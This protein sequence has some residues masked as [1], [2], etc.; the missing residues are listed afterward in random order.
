MGPEE[1][2]TIVSS[3]I[4]RLQS[5]GSNI[6][7]GIVLKN[8]LGPGGALDGKPVAKADVAQAVKDT[9]AQ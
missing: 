4:T 3:V 9:L 6:N 5:E 8:L 1:I 2:R 7:P